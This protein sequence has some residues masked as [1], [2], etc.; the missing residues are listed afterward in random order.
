[1]YTIFI[2][3]R[4]HFGVN[5]TNRTIVRAPVYNTEYIILHKEKWVALVTISS[6]IYFNTNPKGNLYK[7]S[8]LFPYT[9]PCVHWAHEYTYKYMFERT[10]NPTKT[11]SL[12]PHV[13]VLYFATIGIMFRLEVIFISAT[14]IIYVP[15][16]SFFFNVQTLRLIDVSW[17]C[18]CICV[19]VRMWR[20]DDDWFIF[21]SIQL[22]KPK[23]CA[24]LFH[25]KCVE[26]I[27][28]RIFV[29]VVVV[30]NHQH[31]LEVV[32]LK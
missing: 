12:N 22:K 23:R 3:Y 26:Y 11:S 24:F 27:L 29:V 13:I 31:H 28:L 1:M 20:R 32:L 10:H 5:I 4:F 25:A 17:P 14:N 30:P 9:Y 18:V 16:F 19:S 7:S 8:Y 21:N 6:T 2:F 15:F